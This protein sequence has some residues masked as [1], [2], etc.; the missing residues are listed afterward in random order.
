MEAHAG[1][2][3]I[4]Q[5][6]RGERNAGWKPFQDKPALQI[7]AEAA[8]VGERAR[9]AARWVQV[10]VVRSRRG[11]AKAPPLHVRAGRQKARPM[12]GRVTSAVP[13]HFWRPRK[14]TEGMGMT[15]GWQ[16]RSLGRRKRLRKG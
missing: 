3:V 10:H 2:T 8:A 6:G 14:G 13:R 12:K 9:R 1:I 5:N 4:P 7:G 15:E 11:R 16:K